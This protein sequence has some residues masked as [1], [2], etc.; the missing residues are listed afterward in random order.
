MLQKIV[1]S[2]W[3]EFSKSRGRDFS[4][5]RRATTRAIQHSG[6]H[7]HDRVINPSISE[8]GCNPTREHT[9]GRLLLAAETVNV[10]GEP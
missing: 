9:A 2:F 6:V 3:E 7:L 5:K 8:G 4:P 10:N 1:R